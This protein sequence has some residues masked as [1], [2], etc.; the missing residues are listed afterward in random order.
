MTDKTGIGHEEFFFRLI[1]H[2]ELFIVLL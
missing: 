1:Y 2:V